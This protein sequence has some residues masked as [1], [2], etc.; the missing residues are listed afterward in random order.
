MKVTIL[1]HYRDTLRAL[2]CFQ[3]PAGHDVTGWN[4]HVQDLEALAARLQDTEALVLIRERTEIR[5]PP[6]GAPTQ[7]E[8]DRPAQRARHRRLH[9]AG[10]GGVL[11][12]PSCSTAE[13]TRG[14][15]RRTQPC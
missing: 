10:C 4:D 1:D 13:L 3:K 8:A 6:F 2:A 5:T 14:G 12:T 7:A 11:G 9:A 15:R